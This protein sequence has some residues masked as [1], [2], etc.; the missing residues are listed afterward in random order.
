MAKARATLVMTARERHSLA[1][2][3]IDSVLAA[4]ARP[5][6]FVYLDV[7]SPPWLRARLA[8]RQAAGELEAIR[9]D[10]AL[11]PQEARLRIADTLDTDYAVFLDNDIQ[12]APGWL[13]AL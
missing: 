5:Y 12:V 2:R 4:T 13:D 11:W 7:Q 1:D 9:F 3:A 6:R 10:E 8:Q